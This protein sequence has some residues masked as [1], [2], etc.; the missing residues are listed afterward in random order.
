MWILNSGVS[1]ATPWIPPG[2]QLL[3]LHAARSFND[4]STML[5]ILPVLLYYI[6]KLAQASS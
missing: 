6:L 5:C 1:L 4:V 2:N 3:N